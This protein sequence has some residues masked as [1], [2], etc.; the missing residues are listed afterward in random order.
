MVIDTKLWHI[1]LSH[2]LGVAAERLSHSL[3]PKDCCKLQKK[4]IR[5]LTRYLDYLFVCLRVISSLP[6]DLCLTYEKV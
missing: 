5:I 1:K 4:A 6:R 2:H 3:H